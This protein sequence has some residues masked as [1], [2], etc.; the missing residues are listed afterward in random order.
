M[1]PAPTFASQIAVSNSGESLLCVI[2]YPLRQV[3]VSS[4]R[5]TDFGG[6][7]KR[8]KYI[9]KN[10][11]LLLERRDDEEASSSVSAPINLFTI[12]IAKRWLTRS[13]G[14]FNGSR[15]GGGCRDTGFASLRKDG[16]SR[17][18]RWKAGTKCPGTSKLETCARKA[19]VMGKCTATAFE[20]RLED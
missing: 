19:I 10:R 18:E 14:I 6:R 7:A 4:P 20:K 1:A 16:S 5:Q 17:V 11:F 12:R 9:F 2:Q 13:V 8:T 3:F 15:I